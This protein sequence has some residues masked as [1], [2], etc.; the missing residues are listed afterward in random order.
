MRSEMSDFVR[1][2]I[3]ADNGRCEIFDFV[4][5]EMFAVLTYSERYSYFSN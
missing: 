3:S 2:E 4:K 1:R 5:C